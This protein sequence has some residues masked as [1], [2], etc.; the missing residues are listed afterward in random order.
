[1][2]ISNV[3]G[4]GRV[5]WVGYYGCGYGTGHGKTSLKKYFLDHGLF[6]HQGAHWITPAEGHQVTDNK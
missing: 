3:V 6:S 1:M 5:G 4:C 2:Q